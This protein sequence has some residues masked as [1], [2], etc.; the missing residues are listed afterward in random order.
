MSYETI[1]LT[2]E[3]AQSRKMRA[4]AKRYGIPVSQLWRMLYTQGIAAL[5]EKLPL[6]VDMGMLKDQEA[7]A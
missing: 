5:E 4:L 2:V 7:T 6:L 3:P 1:S